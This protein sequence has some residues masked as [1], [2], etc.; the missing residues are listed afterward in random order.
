MN[1]SNLTYSQITAI[2]QSLQ[3]Y[4]KDMQ[5]VLEDIIALANRI[6]SEDI[7]GGNAAENA[8]SKFN[9]LQAKF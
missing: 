6:G 4:S 2:S 9:T 7:W 3:N 8:K 5:I 1:G